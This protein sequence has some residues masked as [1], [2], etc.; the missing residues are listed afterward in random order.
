[1]IANTN[2]QLTPE[3][4]LDRALLEALFAATLAAR[5]PRVTDPALWKADASLADQM[6]DM[7]AV[8]DGARRLALISV[9][10]VEQLD[11]P[12]LF[13]HRATWEC[14]VWAEVT[15]RDKVIVNYEMPIA[16]LGLDGKEYPE[17]VWGNTWDGPEWPPYPPLA[18]PSGSLTT[19][20]VA[21]ELDI[22]ERRVRAL[23]KSRSVG[24]KIG[25]DWLFTPAEVGKMRGK[26]DGAPGPGRE[27]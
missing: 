11:F 24:V 23:R 16:A 5:P 10:T 18:P 27:D 17:S 26:K 20:Q 21:A 12:R 6:S 3:T 1:M 25:R 14:W 22:S 9:F 15:G 13:N 19:A 7:P 4:D 2:D 8:W